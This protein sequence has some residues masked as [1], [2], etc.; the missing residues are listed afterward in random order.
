M[1]K[2]FVVII[3]LTL[4]VAGCSSQEDKKD[5]ETEKNTNN[6][7]KIVKNFLEH[8]YTEN[9]IKQWSE[10]DEYAS[11]QLKNTVKNQKQTYDDNGITKEMED[12]SLYKNSDNDKEYMYNIKVK[13]TDDNAKN[14]DY[15][16]RY[17]IVKLKNEDGH[18]KVNNL[19]EV[20][21][22]TYNGGD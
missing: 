16:Q 17:G 1:K 3:T 7:T 20:G 2:L 5:R 9:D 18:I 8:S 4:V 15:N 6:T 19:K 14:I 12:I 22:E 10:F 13:K 11:K 21:S